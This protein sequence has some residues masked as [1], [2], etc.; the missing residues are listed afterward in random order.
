MGMRARYKHGKNI[1]IPVASGTVAGD[2]VVVGLI[3]GVA[4]IDR[5]SDGTASITREG[6]HVFTS[7]GVNASGNSAI[8]VGDA[9]YFNS[10]ATPKYN[11]DA[12]GVL[13]G[14]ALSA[15]ASGS[16]GDVEVLLE[17]A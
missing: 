7:K 17:T 9:I 11:K 4:Q 16:T 3:K 1:D 5:Q 12:G 14:Y 8:A 13:I 2:F 15:L 6:S 10:G